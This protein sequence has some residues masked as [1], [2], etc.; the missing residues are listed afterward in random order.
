MIA[1][2][3]FFCLAFAETWLI[4]PLALIAI[5]FSFFFND[6]KSFGKSTFLMLISAALAGWYF[7]PEVQTV[8]AAHGLTMSIVYLAGAYIAG[9][10]ATAF[11]YWFFFN[12]KAK[13]RFERHL[14]ATKITDQAWAEGL[15]EDYKNS[16]RKYMVVNN[17]S[18]LRNI[19]D[20]EGD[21]ELRV[22]CDM[23]PKVKEGAPQAEFDA[24]V[25]MVLP[26]RFSV[27]KS[28]VVGAGSSWPITLIWLLVS[29]VV[30]QLIERIVSMF[31]G[32]FDRIS[33][34]AFGKF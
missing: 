2:I 26:P 23:V 10:V 21:H 30:K 25:A 11:V 8:L 15:D 6:S 31:G 9:A 13:E 3:F 20:D 12:W 18:K 33:K 19:F 1:D 5:G 14:L 32:T 27:C 17:D 7:W 16:I 28:F 34:L 29:R 24:A 4:L 22:L